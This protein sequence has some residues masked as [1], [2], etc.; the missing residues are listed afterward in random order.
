MEPDLFQETPRE[1][2]RRKCLKPAGVD[3][4]PSTKKVQEEV[5]HFRLLSS[6]LLTRH[7]V[8]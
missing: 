3:V 1:S 6:L 4:N 8:K 7:L 5:P 2:L